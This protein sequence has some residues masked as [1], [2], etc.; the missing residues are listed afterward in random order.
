MIIEN[1][2]NMW[3]Y[4]ITRS[5]TLQCWN[6]WF[7]TWDTNN[8]RKLHTSTKLMVRSSNLR[9]KKTLCTRSWCK[10]QHEANREDCEKGGEK[11]DTIVDL[12]HCEDNENWLGSLVGGQLDDFDFQLREDMKALDVCGDIWQSRHSMWALSSWWRKIQTW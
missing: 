9:S 4:G 3:H 8:L 12:L 5:A 2:C 11:N 7:H 1:R 6:W 10:T